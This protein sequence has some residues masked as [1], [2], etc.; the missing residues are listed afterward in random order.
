MESKAPKS[1]IALKVTPEL[2]S[3][4]ERHAVAKNMTTSDLVTAMLEAARSRKP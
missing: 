2:K 4:L 1:T 3:W